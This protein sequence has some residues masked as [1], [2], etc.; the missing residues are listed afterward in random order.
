MNV[1]PFLRILINSAVMGVGLITISA[2]SSVPNLTDDFTTVGVRPPSGQCTVDPKSVA[3]AVSLGT[4]N[5]VGACG[6]QDAWKVS[7]V[8][9]VAFS[10]PARLRC[11]MVGVTDTWIAKI[12]Q[13]AARS[14]FGERVVKLRIV[15]SYACRGRD[16]KHGAKISEHAF[17]NAL[18]VSAFTLASGRVVEVESGWVSGGKESSFLK[19]VHGRSCGPFST[20]LGPEANAAHRNHFHFD[21]GKHGRTG[22]GKYCR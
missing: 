3:D 22:K 6:I 20:V 4:V 10:Q 2:C 18:D 8:G 21:L 9:D 15:A 7:A 17:G 16:N 13:P 19:Q 1:K 11:Q 12:L 14:A 5:G